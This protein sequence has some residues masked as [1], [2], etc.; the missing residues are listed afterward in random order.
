MWWYFVKLT[1]TGH[2]VTYSYGFESHELTG[3]FEYDKKTDKTKI[4]KYAD[5]HSEKAQI[6]AHRLVKLCGAPQERMIAFG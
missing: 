4:I 6:P 5:N 1:E 3:V 2:S